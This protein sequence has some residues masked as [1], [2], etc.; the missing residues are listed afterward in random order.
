MN[1][2]FSNTGMQYA[3]TGRDA[4][5]N[6]ARYKQESALLQAS[7]GLQAGEEVLLAYGWT[8]S[9]WEEIDSRVVGMCAWEERGIGGEMGEDG[10]QYV[11]E[12][13]TSRRGGGVGAHLLRMMRRQALVQGA[14]RVELAVH[15]G[16]R[17]RGWYGRLGLTVC[18]WWEEGTGG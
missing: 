14:G 17:A 6:N 3:N 4:G 18:R 15:N 5:P 13:V 7:T 2:R 1:G 11:E 12:V 10:G 8:R 9:A 16:N